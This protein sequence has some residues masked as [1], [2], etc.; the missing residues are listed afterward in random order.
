MDGAGGEDRVVRPTGYFI[1][2]DE[3]SCRPFPGSHRR[4]ENDIQA[5]SK[6]PYQSAKLVKT[7]ENNF[8][9]WMIIS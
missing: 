5:G 7:I 3:P 6:D 9:H 2:V 4:V 8:V 1:H